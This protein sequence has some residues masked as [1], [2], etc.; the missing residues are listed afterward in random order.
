MWEGV[1]A[2][3]AVGAGLVAAGLWLAAS[4]VK[5]RFRD[6]G[7]YGEGGLV[8]E[9]RG[10][11]YSIGPTFLAANRWNPWAAGVT[12]GTVLLQAASLAAHQ[13]GR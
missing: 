10:R 9:E 2:W 7:D 5:V 4:L 12:A 3:L 6:D 11:R 1:F 13:L 8:W